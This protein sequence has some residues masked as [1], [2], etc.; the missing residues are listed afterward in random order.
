MQ[1]MGNGRAREIYEALLPD[2]FRRP[3]ESDNY[4]LE[5]FIRAKYDR[6]EFMKDSGKSTQRKTRPR[7]AS[8]EAPVQHERRSQ[9]AHREIPKPVQATPPAQDLLSFGPTATQ[10]HSSDFG[11]FSGFQGTPPSLDPFAGQSFVSATPIVQPVA[12]KIDPET[13]FFSSPDS[14]N[15]GLQPQPKSKD[16]IMSLFGSQPVTST[17]MMQSAGTVPVKTASGPNYNV[18][19]PGI[20]MPVGPPQQ[21]MLPQGMGRGMSPPMMGM[22][23]MMM[24]QPMNQ[25][26]GMNQGMPM[27]QQPMGRGMAYNVGPNMGSNP[28][29][30]NTNGYVNPAAFQQRTQPANNMGFM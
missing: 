24:A 16:S 9:T 2:N 5:Q 7:A 14:S 18:V 22:N 13:V 6:K 23:P 1:E 8:N 30:V 19:L 28:T 29:F 25:G 21:M 20:G 3:N 4:A 17:P 10:Q 12:S 27:N 26:Y 15:Q 11:D